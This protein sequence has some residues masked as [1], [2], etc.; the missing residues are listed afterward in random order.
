MICSDGS[1]A[2]RPENGERAKKAAEGT[3]NSPP[4][5]A[6]R[7]RG[8]AGRRLTFSLLWFFCYRL[9]YLTITTTY[10]P[11][12]TLCDT[13]RDMEWD[14]GLIYGLL[15]E[16]RT[17]TPFFFCLFFSVPV[18][19]KKKTNN[20]EKTGNKNTN[21]ITFGREEGR[22]PYLYNTHNRY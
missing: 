9:D 7:L 21:T 12:D 2:G 19:P 17:G 1:G 14:H 20:K 8:V 22:P 4:P 15:T 13:K 18:P 16:R 5:L 3:G 11:H 6:W 10:P